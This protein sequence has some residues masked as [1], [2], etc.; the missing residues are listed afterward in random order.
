MCNFINRFQIAWIHMHFFLHSAFYRFA[1]SF[2]YV[3]Q[4]CLSELRKQTQYTIV[5]GNHNLYILYSLRQTNA[6]L[7]NRRRYFV[8]HIDCSQSAR[9]QL[10]KL[11][12]KNQANAK[13]LVHM[14]AH[15]IA[16]ART[17]SAVDLSPQ[18]FTNIYIL[19]AN[20]WCIEWATSKH[21]NVNRGK[22]R[23]AFGSEA[24]AIWVN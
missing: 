19:I 23:G 1:L 21:H 11:I 8:Q 7:A 15:C 5:I 17:R 13:N 2:L 3:W 24:A 14:C 4:T 18:K 16:Q 20:I 12:H 10:L 22:T 9:V 6:L